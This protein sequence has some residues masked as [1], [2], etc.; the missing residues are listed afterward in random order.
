MK[1]RSSILYIC[2]AILLIIVMMNTRTEARTGNSGSGKGKAKDVAAY[3]KYDTRGAKADRDITS[4][5][6]YTV[7]KGDTVYGISRKFGVTPDSII[8]KNRCGSKIIPGM[9]LKIP[10]P[11]VKIKS[12]TAG[13]CSSKYCKGKPDFQWP[14]KKVTT[15]RNDGGEGVKSIGI[16]IKSTPNAAVYASARGVVKKVGYMRGYGKYIVITHE[17]RY[18]TVYSNMDQVN[19]REGQTV[20]KGSVLGR[21]SSDSR[22]HFQIGKAGKPENPLEYLPSRG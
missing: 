22:L 2:F 4:I 16:I 11:K 1:R 3:G 10:V 17:N 15:C 12:K 8:K 14:L 7:R 13:K 21:I 20:K 9:K 18:I 19:V 5:K 6:I